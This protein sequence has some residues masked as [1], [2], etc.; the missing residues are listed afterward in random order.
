M[1]ETVSYAFMKS[2]AMGKGIV[3]LLGMLSMW[4][5]SIMIRKVVDVRN[6]R[7]NCKAFQED[8][9][10][11]NSSPLS[12]AG[13]LNKYSGPLREICAEGLSALTDILQL[14]NAGVQ[15]LI[16]QGVM[17]RQLSPDEFDK[18]RNAMQMVQSRYNL[19]L[20]D[21]LTMLGSIVALSPYL[22]LFGTVWG[23][24]ATFIGIAQVGRPDLMAIA[25]GI[26]GA[27]LTTVAGLMVAIPSLLGN[28]Y[29][30]STVQV[31]IVE[32]DAFVD[33]FITS[34]KLEG[35]QHNG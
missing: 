2:D 18:V 9:A 4:S 1:W 7:Q 15:I 32:M 35:F 33:S 29:I 30:A 21:N 19:L 23:V 24:M 13:S 22:G 10:A 28:N 34:L 6:I 27:L 5:W 12:I 26:S 3:I 25:P 20:E 31:T 11:A 16:R 8:F 17:P 14:D